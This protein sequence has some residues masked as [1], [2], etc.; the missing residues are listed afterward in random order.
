MTINHH[1]KGKAVYISADVGSG[2]LHNPHP[3]LKRFLADLA[4]RARLPLELEA[5]RAIEMTAFLPDPGHLYVHL[6]NN[7]TPNL[8]LSLTRQQLR[9][10]FYLEEVLPVH[11]VRIRFNDFKPRSARM[12]I[13]GQTLEVQGNSVRVPRVDLHEV[14]VLEV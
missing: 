5:P 8:P 14:I 7:P 4:A 1:G 13:G 11:D 10:F 3:V 2:Y 12:P 6:L 9:S